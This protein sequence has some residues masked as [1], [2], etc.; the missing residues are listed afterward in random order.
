MIRLLHT[1]DWQM[2]LRAKHVAGAASAIRDA[3]LDAARQLIQT[4]NTRGVDAVV[5]AGD[6]FEDNTVGD[7]QVH[8]VLKVL[9]ASRAPVYVLPGNHDPLSPDSV[10]L[11]PS[12]KGRPAHVH[13]LDSDKG[14][15]V[16]GTGTLLIPAPLR[17]KKGLKDPT[18]DWGPRVEGKDIR[19]GVAHGSLRIEGKH[20][21]DDFP[22]ALDAVTRSNLDYLALG[23]WHGQYVHQKRAAYSGTHEATKFGEDGAGQALLVEIASHGAMPQLTSIPTGTLTWKTLELDLSL[24]GGLELAR[25]R[26]A[27]SEWTSPEKTLLR[28][29]TRGTSSEEDTTALRALIEEVQGQGLLHVELDRHDVPREAAEGRLAELASSSALLTALVERLSAKAPVPGM[30]VTP[31]GIHPAARQLL[32]ELVMEVWK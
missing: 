15:S 21:A 10:Y 25:V 7:R 6:I 28:L 27:V 30:A 4:A 3:R 18:A 11:R 12:W 9:K 24:G 31:E 1:A 2:G 29:R 13:M 19:I 5:L 26:T 17:Q 16:P 23:H 8:E 32:S 22:I 20:S 14:V